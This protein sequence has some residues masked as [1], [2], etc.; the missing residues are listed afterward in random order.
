MIL[1]WVWPKRRHTPADQKQHNGDRITRTACS[2][3]IFFRA[4]NMQ[5]VLPGILNGTSG[6]PI[7][8]A[9]CCR[10]DKHL[11]GTPQNTKYW[12]ATGILWMQ[13]NRTGPRCWHNKLHANYT[14]RLPSQELGLIDAAL[15]QGLEFKIFREWN[16][17]RLLFFQE[18]FTST[19][20]SLGVTGDLI[21]NSCPKVYFKWGIFK[22]LFNYCVLLLLLCLKWF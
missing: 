20:Y 3:L 11:C 9:C 8:L 2:N 4:R 12:L 17:I 16:G 19:V 13:W 1:H 14:R 10:H 21:W 5:S 7:W 22:E 15:C 6:S 18:K